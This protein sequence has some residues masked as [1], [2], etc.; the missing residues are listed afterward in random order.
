MIKVYSGLKGLTVFL[1]FIAGVVL[2]ISI[3]IW[4]LA[5]AAEL[6]LPFLIVLSYLLIAV[7]LLV[8]LPAT[9]FKDLRRSLAMYCMTMS[10]ALGVAAWMMSFFFIVKNLGFWGILFA[11]LFQLLAPL[12]IAGAVLKGAW[13]VAGHLLLWISFS[14]TMRF[15]SQW[16]L[17]SD[18]GP[19]Q[20][21]DVIDIE[22]IT[23]H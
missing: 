18:G 10:K 11:F 13:E 17:S 16:L 20:K 9:F 22:A 19:T 14:Y 1:F 6:M 21:G 23:K 2:V 7:F 12:A 8:I 3:F 15:Y 4:G 5:K